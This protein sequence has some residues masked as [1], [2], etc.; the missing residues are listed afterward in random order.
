MKASEFKRRYIA[1]LMPRFDAEKE[2]SEDVV[3][4]ILVADL[5]RMILQLED[6]CACGGAPATAPKPVEHE[7]PA[8]RDIWRQPLSPTP[9]YEP[10]PKYW[11][12]YNSSHTKSP[13]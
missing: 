9:F 6:G 7:Y 11:L 3:L 4:G 13:D 5:E 10:L 2:R 1:E 8:W 12:F